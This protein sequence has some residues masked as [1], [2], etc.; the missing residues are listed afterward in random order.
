MG[1]KHGQR[2]QR[3]LEL[4][5][6]LWRVVVAAPRPSTKRLKRSLG[7]A[8]LREAQRLRW[9]IVAEFKAELASEGLANN[10]SLATGEVEAWRAALAA[11]T[12]EPLDATEGAFSDHLDRLTM[13]RGEAEAVNFADRV[14]GR[15]TPLD[16]HLEAF[17]SSRG[18][19]RADTRRRHEWAVG[20][21][22][23]WLK[24]NHL[25]QTI[26]ALDR[27]TAIR[28]VDQLP[29]GRPDP[30]RL[31]LQWQWMVRR[32][33]VGVDV[34]NGLQAAPRRPVEPER[35]FTDAE[36]LALLSGN[37]EPAMGLLMR[38]LALTGARLAAVIGMRVDLERMT[39]TFPAQ[40]RER[41]PRT[42]PLHSHLASSLEGFS[43][44]PWEANGASA[45]FV[46]YRRSVL[47]PDP[48]GR[49]RAVV[50][51]HSWRRWF[52]SKA[53]Q[54][55]QPEHLIAAV[56]G[57]KRPGLTLGRYSSGPS[58]GQLR[59]CVESVRLPV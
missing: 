19:L 23:A 55:G 16:E 47:G 34:W 58:M 2:D 22:S 37:P 48:P 7:T 50:N 12:G 29:P 27:K 38:V 3:Y 18:E 42:I 9:P 54:A 15:S 33:M 4:H 41:G 24:A 40:K 36:A 45:R 17:L 21:L 6:R 30:K 25:P 49:R 11:S 8:S 31:S 10:V 1:S 53:E 26:Q 35:A 13:L 14:Y 39:A 44:W 43:G 5:Q 59:A 32:E 56:V 51:A 28:Y 46:L 57:H 52:I 20:S